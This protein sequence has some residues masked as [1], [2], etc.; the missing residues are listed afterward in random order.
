M[1]RLIAAVT[2]A[3]AIAGTA[4][5]A[6]QSQQPPAGAKPGEVKMETVRVWTNDALYQNIL[7]PIIKA[8]NEG[9]GL[10]DGIN[11]EYKVFGSD[12]HD[13]LKV[14][15]A[16]GQGPELYKFVGTVKEPF[17]KSGWMV[18]IDSLPGGK[19]FLAPYADILLKGYNTF[20]GKSYSVPLKVLTTKFVYN[21]DLLAKSG[22]TQ[23][24]KTWDDVIA[25]ARKVT[26]DNNGE[27]FGYGVHLKDAASS[28][29]W[30]FATQFATSVGHMGYN[31]KTG[32]Y[33]FTD[34]GE[35][36]RRILQM[37]DEGL[38]FPGGEG[39][40]NDELRAQFA[41]GRIAMLTGVSWDVSGLASLGMKFKLGVCDTPVIDP[42]HKFKNYAQIADVLC[43]G[44]SASALPAKAM[45][46]YALMH[47]EQVQLTIQ[48]R[49]V[50]FMA[51]ESIQ[52][53][54][55][56]N[57]KMAGTAEFGDTANSYFTMTPPDGLISVEGQ[58][59]QN[60]IINLVGAGK[61]TDVD[62]VLADLEK[63]YNAAL[64]KA[65]AAGTDFSAYVAKDWNVVSK[66]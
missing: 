47:S 52:K 1:K 31:F 15:L 38:M 25:Y 16:A 45:K 57:F 6:G 5:A 21:K 28:G 60:T 26:K 4:F 10:K 29:K 14:A 54:S 27:A 59:Y 42:A 62:K 40:S 11:I 7:E 48:N 55:S 3:T 35:N 22:I 46:V 53:K 23:P 34:F 56:G 36:L 49:E 19:E 33:A 63:R 51:L 20:D 13:V 41:A 65:S 58:P 43:L 50:D 39:M 24:P 61:L 30:Y 17:I 64:D 8:Y 18:P 9:E 44:P 32:R 2:A 66:K 37:R 12:Y